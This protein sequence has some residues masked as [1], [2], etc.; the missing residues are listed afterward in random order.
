MSAYTDSLVSLLSD[1]FGHKER[2]EQTGYI[3]NM[4]ERVLRQN[5]LNREGFRGEDMI[6]GKTRIT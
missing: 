5:E 3:C 2:D 6:L 1:I 4:R